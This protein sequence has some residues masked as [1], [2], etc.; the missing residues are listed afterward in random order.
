MEKRLGLKYY[1]PAEDSME[2]WERYS[3]PIGNG[4]F[5]ASVFGG[6]DRERVQFTAN[7]F[8]NTYQN[9]GV[10]DFAE[11]YIETENGEVKD[12]ERGLDLTDGTAY[13]RYR[14]QG[15][16]VKRTAFADYPDKVFVYRIAVENGRKNIS[17]R[18][19]IPYL[20][21]RSVQDG[22]REGKTFAEG[23][24]H[25]LRES[26]PLRELTGEA[27]LSAVTDGVMRVTDDGIK[28]IGASEVTFFA[29]LGTNYKLC[30]EVFADGCNKALGEDP[31]DELT[32]REK[33]VTE[34][35]YDALYERHRSDYRSLMGR[36]AIDLGGKEDSRSTEE[37]ICALRNG[38]DV[39]YLIETYFQFGRHLLVSS[40]R[41]GTPPASLQGT[42]SAHDKSPWGSGI[43][44]NINVQMNYWC[45]LSTG[46]A[47]TFWAYADYWKAY[48]PRAEEYAAEWVREFAPERKEEK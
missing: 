4:Y 7:V 23:A 47:E 5:G 1:Q 41:K 44:H 9:G 34:S 17:A 39:P 3:L 19:S 15:A 22:G 10:S 38:E 20:N 12:Y 16:M 46:L 6:A 36:A 43:W 11:L 25:V 13:S 8:A 26:L 29:V 31:H 2:G 45:A 28:V 27:R 48:L 40:S 24:A 18:F 14:D 35:G 30:P 33:R 21:A 42:W 32:K 37:L